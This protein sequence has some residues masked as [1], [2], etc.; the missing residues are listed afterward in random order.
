VTYPRKSK[1]K[2]VCYLKL[3]LLHSTWMCIRALHAPVT[4]ARS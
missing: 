1:F 3:C 2:P 4:P